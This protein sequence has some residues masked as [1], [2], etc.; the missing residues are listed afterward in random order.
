MFMVWWCMVSGVCVLVCLRIYSIRACGK[1][2]VYVVW[3]LAETYMV[4]SCVQWMWYPV[5]WGMSYTCMYRS[6]IYVCGVCERRLWICAVCTWMKGYEGVIGS[7]M[8]QSFQLSLQETLSRAPERPTLFLRTQCHLSLVLVTT[9][10]RGCAQ[11]WHGSSMELKLTA[12]PWL[13][14][15]VRTQGYTGFAHRAHASLWKGAFLLCGMDG[16]LDPQEAS[17]PLVHPGKVS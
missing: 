6:V 11:Q 8:W 15:I 17:L 10:G 2:C 4:H 14:E 1:C 7:S 3:T 9:E 12:K 13:S 16:Y 5:E